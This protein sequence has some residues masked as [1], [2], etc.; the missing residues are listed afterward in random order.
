MSKR[1]NLLER[2]RQISLSFPDTSEVIQFGHPFFKWL[3]KPFAIY[4]GDDGDRL[5]IKV[6]KE[7]QPVFLADPRFSKTPYL[8]HHGW[9]SLALSN[10]PDWEEIEELI[11]G[12]YEF[13][14]TPKQKAK[15]KQK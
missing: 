3:N 9:V 11:R 12:S 4:S 2:I 7:S 15:N 13:V 8:G 5:S 6:E 10:K 14:S 1:L